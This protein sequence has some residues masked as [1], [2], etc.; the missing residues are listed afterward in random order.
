MLVGFAVGDVVL[1]L[2]EASVVEAEFLVVGVAEGAGGGEEAGASSPRIFPPTP[3][4]LPFISNLI[5]S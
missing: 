3:S 1:E 2:E 5:C 4:T